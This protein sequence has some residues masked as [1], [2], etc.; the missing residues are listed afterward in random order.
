MKNEP[1]DSHVSFTELA[2]LSMPGARLEAVKG[3][4]RFVSEGTLQVNLPPDQHLMV[5]DFAYYAGMIRPWEWG[6]EY[7]EPWRVASHA[8]WTPKMRS[9]AESYLMRHFGVERADDIPKVGFS[10]VGIKKLLIDTSAI[11]LI[12]VYSNPCSPR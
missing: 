5:I 11:L 10:R 1:H 3:E 9:L 4:K 2:R 7:F 12:A 6:L 8:H